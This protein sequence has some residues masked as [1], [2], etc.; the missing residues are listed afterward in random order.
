MDWAHKDPVGRILA[1]QAQTEG[2]TLII[3]DKA[4]IDAPDISTLW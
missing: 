2:L 4:F 1:A 3:C